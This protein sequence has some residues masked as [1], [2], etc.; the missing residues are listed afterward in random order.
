MTQAAEPLV[1][2]LSA[3]IERYDNWIDAELKKEQE[4]NAVD[5]TLYHYT[6]VAGLRGILESGTVWFTDFRHMNDPSEITHGIEISH[7]VIR[8][9][10]TGADGRVG[11]FL[12]CLADMMRLEN[13]SRALEYFIGSFSRA[14]DDL[15]QWR[16]YGD[17]GRGVAIG[18][19]PHLF[20]VENTTDMK[21][22]EAAFVSP[23]VYDLAELSRRH[24]VAIDQ[25]VRIFVETASAHP[26]LLTTPLLECRLCKTLRAG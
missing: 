14:R 7:D 17:N 1:A 26:A 24:L 18:F 19:A 21:P 2:A 10:K 6:N 15:G 9:I 3:A 16:A 25:A 4:N 20:G 11:L 5:V 13:F 8:D 12:D 22:D 23:V